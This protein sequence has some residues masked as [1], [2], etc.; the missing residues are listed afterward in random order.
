M[1]KENNCDEIRSSTSNQAFPSSPSRTWGRA[2]DGH[3]RRDLII[4]MF[5]MVP[6][7][8]QS[9]RSTL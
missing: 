8:R 3:E 4:D 6:R 9:H 7:I 5:D 1:R 2:R